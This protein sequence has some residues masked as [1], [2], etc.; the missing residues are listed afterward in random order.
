MEYR[1]D[2]YNTLPSTNTFLKQLATEGEPAGKVIIAKEQTG[3]RGRF[4]RSFFSPFGTGLYMS[5]LIRPKLAAEQALFITTSTAVAV[6]NAIDCVT[7]AISG[8]SEKA[9]IKWVNDI[10]HKGKKVSGILTESEIENGF[11]KYAVVGIGV[12]LFEPENGFPDDLKNVAS[13]VLR[14]VSET[15]TYSLLIKE[16]LHNFDGYMRNPHKMEYLNEYREKSILIDKKVSFDNEEG[17]VLGIDDNA[18]LIV[19]CGKIVKILNSG[20][21]SVK[22]Y[23]I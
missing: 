9:G 11:L 2:Y 13:S 15:N 22:A 21:V 10:F 20:E 8:E 1:I 7:G 3:G 14:N 5:I 4:G 18:G 17:T 16:I 6:A 23:E 12:N 19:Q